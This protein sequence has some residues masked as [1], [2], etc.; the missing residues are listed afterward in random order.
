[1]ETVN[2]QLVIS[3]RILGFYVNF[4]AENTNKATSRV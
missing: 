4:L 1:M 3:M 2:H